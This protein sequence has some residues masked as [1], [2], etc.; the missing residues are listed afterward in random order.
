MA[1]GKYPVAED[2]GGSASAFASDSRSGAGGSSAEDCAGAAGVAAGVTG[3][4]GGNG[5][6]AGLSVPRSSLCVRSI[7]A[8]ASISADKLIA[9]GGAACV[10][11]CICLREFMSS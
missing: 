3:A 1:A 9:A 11:M 2:V 5:S 7:A 6:S 4:A 8:S 10:C